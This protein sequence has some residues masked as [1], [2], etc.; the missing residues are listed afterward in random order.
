MQFIILVGLLNGL[1]YELWKQGETTEVEAESE[2]VKNISK[3]EVENKLK[4]TRSKV[5]KWK[6][7][8][9]EVTSKYSM[10]KLHTP[11]LKDLYLHYRNK[12]WKGETPE[13]HINHILLSVMRMGGEEAPEANKKRKEEKWK[14]GGR[15]GEEE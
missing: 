11:M 3:R 14:R 4:Q 6:S 8:N 5:V 2:A 10:F 15:S 1:S 12:N 9:N 13:M 7:A